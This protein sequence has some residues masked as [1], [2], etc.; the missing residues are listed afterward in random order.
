MSHFHPVAAYFSK[1][2]QRN[3]DFSNT[4]KSKVNAVARSAGLNEDR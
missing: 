2:H 1:I 3:Y 4:V